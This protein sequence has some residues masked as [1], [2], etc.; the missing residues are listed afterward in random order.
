MYCCGVVYVV[1]SVV[2]GVVNVVIV[3]VIVVVCVW[4]CLWGTTMHMLLCVCVV[5]D[6][7]N[8]MIVNTVWSCCVYA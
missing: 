6:F 3:V 8:L 1:L 4:V 7:V 5:G 2:V